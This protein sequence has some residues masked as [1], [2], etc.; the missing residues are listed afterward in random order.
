MERR[1]ALALSWDFMG[2]LTSALGDGVTLQES[3]Y[4]PARRRLIK[5][6]GDF[7]THYVS[8]HFL[9]RDGIATRYILANGTRVARVE[10]AELAT[11]VL[12]DLAP[13]RGDDMIRANDAWSTWARQTGLREGEAG[14]SAGRLLRSAARRLL[15]E[16]GPEL[17]FLHYDHL[18]SAVLATSALPQRQ[19]AVHGRRAF[20]PGGIE[21]DTLVGWVDPFGYTG[22]ERDVATGLIHFADRYYDPELLRW[23]ALD[24]AFA[25]VTPTNI[26]KLGEAT[27]GYA[28]VGNNLINTRDPHGRQ[29]EV[30]YYPKSDDIKVTG[31][32]SVGLFKDF[33]STDRMEI[34]SSNADLS[35]LQSNDT[36]H[37]YGHGNFGAYIGDHDQVKNSSNTALGAKAVV[38]QMIS[39]GLKTGIPLTI[40][41]DTC[42]SGVA[43]SADSGTRKPMAERIAKQ[44]AKEGF[45]DVTVEGHTGF[46]LGSG[47]VARTLK[48]TNSKA[49]FDDVRSGAPN[50]PTS[51][52][53]HIDKKGKV[54][55]KGPAFKLNAKKQDSNSRHSVKPK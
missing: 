51:V 8:D 7:V 33:G 31:A 24:A 32:F 1:G 9:L 52:S 30:V 47:K 22:Q 35:T 11:R 19:T 53:W 29:R 23:S 50:D 12:S 49:S 14:D 36:V 41:V 10:S 45:R 42:N 3:H 20:Y 38:K 18:G 27:T 48:F 43:C 25:H 46:L 40:K 4:G 17:T 2:R 16:T 6:E 34:G 28:Y 39:D 5:E 13:E 21:R 44:L 37:V 15:V 26:T 55:R 54:T